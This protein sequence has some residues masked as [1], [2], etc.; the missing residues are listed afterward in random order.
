MGKRLN[1]VEYIDVYN[2]VYHNQIIG[3]DIINLKFL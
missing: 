3:E 2:K 1:G